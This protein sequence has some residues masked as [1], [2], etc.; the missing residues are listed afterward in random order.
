MTAVADARRGRRP[1]A[2]DR[3]LPGRA[4][5]L[6]Y[7][8]IAPT[9]VTLVVVGLVPFLYAVYLS[10]H[11][12]PY[13]RI[14]EF[15][16]FDNYRALLSDAR[17][18]HSVWVA[19]VFVGIAVPVEFVLGMLGALVLNQKI[20]LR[21]LIVPMLFVPT[22]MAPI[23]VALLWKIMLA[24]S[25]GLISYNVLER[26]KIV[27]ETSV[28]GSADLALYTL[29]LIDVWQWTPF[30]IIA[31]YAG[32]QALPLNPYRAA[33]VDGAS[34]FQMFVRITV[35]LMM[36]LMAVMVLLRIIDA[37]KVF[38]TIFL[39]TGGGPGNATESPSVFGYKLVFEFW[40]LGE[41]SAF[42]VV[43]WLLFFV[44]CNAFYQI[45]KNQLKA[46]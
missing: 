42:A 30:M 29:I 44:F 39:L 18:W 37:F 3:F 28:F 17:F 14:G 15:S 43:I 40:K 9:M 34:P 36:P 6:G 11:D 8:L 26:L 33:R 27:S 2:A 31:F 4:S 10:L 19:L 25:W 38:D 13:G 46:F 20:R 7:L 16:G 45:A 23:V 24:G 5:R 41:A 1:L 32:L 21:G 35:P 22:M 12:V